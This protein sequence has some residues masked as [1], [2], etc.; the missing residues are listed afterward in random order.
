MQFYHS[1][2]YSTNV[3]GCWDMYLLWRQRKSYMHKRVPAA[4]E[5]VLSSEEFAKNQ[6]YGL[7]KTAFSLVEELQ[8][9]AL[10]NVT[11]LGRLSAK[12]YN[13]TSRVTGLA[14]GSFTHCLTFSIVGDVISTVVGLPLE[15]YEHFVLEEKHGF[16]KM[17]LKEFVLDTLKAFLLRATL[18]YPIQTA[19]IQWV[20]QRFGERFPMYFFLATT[21]IIVLFTFLFPTVI[22]PLF[23]KFSDLDSNGQLYQKIKGLADRVGFPLTKVYT[24][25]GSRRSHHSNAYLY[26]F[27]KSKRIVLYDTLIAQ[28]DSDDEQIVAVLAHELGHW[29]MG[30]TYYLLGAGLAQ[31]LAFSYGAK[32]VIFN[33]NMYR[34]FGFSNMDPVIGFDVYSQSFLQ[35]LYTVWGY[36]MSAVSRQFEFQADRYAVT[37][38]YASKLRKALIVMVKENKSGLTPDPL[39]SALTYSHPP[40]IER[41]AAIERAEQSKEGSKPKD[42]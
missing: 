32:A 8:S 20:V 10:A 3:V 9:L 22:Q 6:A 18:L 41:L 4:F 27:W 33:E 26:G 24:M 15:Y 31:L 5:T 2:L 35:P 7:D 16:N 37:L 40:T 39:Y 13:Y 36:A 30:H 25:D 34:Q 23:N 14:L 28:M 11:L 21:V 29:K 12:L 42:Q 19:V 17:T 38:G 1:A